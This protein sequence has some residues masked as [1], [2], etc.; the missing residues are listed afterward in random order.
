M[1]KAV[2]SSAPAVQLVEYSAEWPLAFHDVENRLR[3]I[4]PSSR[5]RL[6]HIGSTSVPGLVSKDMVDVQLGVE[7]LDFDLSAPLQQAGFLVR[8]D[9][10]RDHTPP[11][12]INDPADWEKRF[13]AGTA[14]RRAVNLHVRRVGA[15]NWRYALLFR[16]FLRS[17]PVARAAYARAKVLLAPLCPS[18]D[19]YADAKDPICD[20][21]MLSAAA[22]AVQTGWNPLEGW[23]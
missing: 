12:G 13:A 4:F 21:V 17:S 5:I 1:N 9:I 20:L 15:S 18:V 8:D 22:W 11:G 10:R 23:R 14:G 2:N 3:M 19:V 6:D 16:D 7:S